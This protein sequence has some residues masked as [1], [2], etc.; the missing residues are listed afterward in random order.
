V[1][2]LLRFGAAFAALVIFC[3]TALADGDGPNSPSF[4]LFGGTDAWFYGAFA[5]AGGIWA[6]AGLDHDGFAGILQQTHLPTGGC[7]WVNFS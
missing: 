6:P 5:N 7:R 4:L 1:S 3:T 2:C